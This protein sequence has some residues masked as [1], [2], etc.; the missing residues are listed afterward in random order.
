M[1][2]EFDDSDGGGGSSDITGVQ[3]SGNTVLEDAEYI[4]F[5]GTSISSVTDNG[6][7]SVTVTI[8]YTDTDTRIELLTDGTSQYTNLDALDITTSGALSVS[9]D[10]SGTITLDGVD[11][12]T[13]IEALVD[14]TTQYT[15]LTALDITTTGS[16]SVSD[17]GS[18]T[19]TLD[20]TDT[21]TRVESKIDGTS[22]YTDTSSLNFDTSGALTATDD[23]TSGQLTIGAS[24]GGYDIN[25][26]EGGSIAS[27]D[28][29][30]L[31][32]TELADSSSI[33]IQVAELTVGACEAAP[34]GIDMQIV[35][36][37]NAGSYTVQTTV[38]SG[39]DSTVYDRV[40]GSPLASYT[41]TS[42]SAQSVGVIVENTTASSY[43]V[44]SE[45][46]GGIN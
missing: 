30:I 6:D 46:Q 23:A 36:F 35:T 5:S 41:N 15:D 7:G 2:I 27:S 29:G 43:T 33:D 45:A 1:G 28:Y 32:V 21:D 44:H 42:G 40:T 11:T 22:Q 37:D 9:D 14:G 18:G 16:L 34:S 8:D 31:Y 24:A 19:L 25:A 20:G 17:D 3:E 38:L 10:G 12:D 4:D 13:R 26:D 39:D